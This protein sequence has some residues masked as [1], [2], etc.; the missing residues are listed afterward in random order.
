MA[1]ELDPRLVNLLRAT[2]GL[3][4]A[5]RAIGGGRQVAVRLDRAGGLQLRQLAG[6]RAGNS[7][8]LAG[9]TFEWPKSLH[10]EGLAANDNGGLGGAGETPARR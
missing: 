6:A 5:L 8:G 10:L 7:I 1:G 4:D 3:V 2:L 9:V